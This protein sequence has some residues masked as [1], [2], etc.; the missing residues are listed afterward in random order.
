MNQIPPGTTFLDWAAAHYFTAEGH[1]AD[2]T[3]VKHNTSHKD[4]YSFENIG[5]VILWDL[6]A[7]TIL[8]DFPFLNTQIPVLNY[9]GQDLRHVPYM[10]NSVTLA[11]IFGTNI[12]FRQDPQHHWQPTAYFV[13]ESSLQCSFEIVFT[14]LNWALRSIWPSIPQPHDFVSLITVP[15]SNARIYRKF[16]PD[17]A[18]LKHDQNRDLLDQG[19]M[20]SFMPGEIK[21]REKFNISW[22]DNYIQP[23][24]NH[25]N[26]EMPSNKGREREVLQVLSQLRFYM[27]E[28]ATHLMVMGNHPTYFHPVYGY[29]ATDEQLV[30][31]KRVPGPGNSKKLFVSRGFRWVPVNRLNNEVNGMMAL[32]YIHMLA[33]RNDGLATI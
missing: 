32:L 14:D 25:M 3:N 4:A 13:H 15:G 11:P 9:V 7:Q 16:L 33:S 30:L 6:D 21:P 28:C 29:I 22:L 31:V 5:R 2:P 17:R 24:D 1:E 18:T 27:C 26:V 8:N 10:K 23:D 12:P 20:P 19:P